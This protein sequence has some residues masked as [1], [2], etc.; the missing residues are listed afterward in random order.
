MVLKKGIRRRRE[1]WQGGRSGEGVMEAAGG[2]VVDGFVDDARS[3]HHSTRYRDQGGNL[4][5]GSDHRHICPCRGSLGSERH[6]Y[7]R[8]LRL[9]V[10]LRLLDTP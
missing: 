5:S 8:H 10:G 1:S 6:L 9:G 7:Q 4:A 2:W 3:G